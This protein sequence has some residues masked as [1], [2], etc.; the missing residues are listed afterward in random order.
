VPTSRSK[1]PPAQVDVVSVVEAIYADALVLA[2]RAWLPK[3]LERL[4]PFVPATVG[5]VAYA[6]EMA[7]PAGSW[8]ASYPVAAG[9]PTTLADE[10]FHSFRHAP[11]SFRRQLFEGMGA[12]GTY[13]QA[14]GE[15]LTEQHAYGAKAA[16]R[17]AMP[18]AV[19]LNSVD[20]DGRG[21]LFALNVVEQTRLSPTQR[22]RLSLVAAHI[23]A[24]RRLVTRTRSAP[25]AIFEPGGRVA[26]VEPDHEAAL[27]SLRE[28]LLHLRAQGARAQTQDETL[29]AWQALVAGQYSL[30][31][32]F[33]AD[34]KRH[35]VAHA[36]S[37]GVRDPRGLTKLEAAVAGWAM[38]GHSQKLIGY[39]LG[40]TVGT[41]GGLLARAF[42]KLRVRSRAELVQ[43]LTP[44][45]EASTFSLPEGELLLFSAVP[46][47]LAAPDLARLTP[48]E[49][50]VAQSAAAGLSNAAIA[51]A[52]GKSEHTVT[53]QLSSVFRKLQISSRAE[54]VARLS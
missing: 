37:P 5:S 42:H 25:L 28:R 6:Y 24:A 47:A 19:Y 9:G 2:P 32:T 7:G 8:Q 40:L 14:M 48:A 51:E 4:R 15:L 27:P 34:G 53:N 21:V 23:G 10:V 45:G 30:V 36:N 43:R 20:P 16:E 44:P 13:S 17:L 3:V 35:V 26:H 12:A 50:A 52:L 49:R 33:D 1:S 39:E 54:L 31:D 46:S 38:R 18:D 11:P 29:A 22:R 41:V